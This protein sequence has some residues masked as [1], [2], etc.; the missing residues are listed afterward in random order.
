MK[1]IIKFIHIETI[2]NPKFPRGRLVAPLKNT[3]YFYKDFKIKKL[4]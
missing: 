1:N 3:I 2:K 4:L